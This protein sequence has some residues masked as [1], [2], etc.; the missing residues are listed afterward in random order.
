MMHILEKHN[1]VSSALDYL[2]SVPRLGRNNL[3]LADAQGHL[4]VF[5]SGRSR[6]GL[7]ETQE[8]TLVNTNHF[9]SAEMRACFVDMDPPDARGRTFRRYETATAA[10]SAAHGQI[11]VVF[12][13]HLMASHNGPLASLCCHPEASSQMTTISASIFL[14][15]RRAM[16]FC[17]GLPCEGRYDEFVL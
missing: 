8:G 17:H 14:P 3:I 7:L 12:A 13:Q 10:L 4:A 6:Y 9:V 5:E 11:D 2:R 15:A 1:S 16:L